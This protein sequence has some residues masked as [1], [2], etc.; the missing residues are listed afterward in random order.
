MV[1][2][3]CLLKSLHDVIEIGKLRSTMNLPTTANLPAAICAATL[4][5]TYYHLHQPVR[6]CCT[7]LQGT[8]NGYRFESAHPED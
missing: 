5:Q 3:N 1:V 4:L 6:N 2:N 8:T 7:Y